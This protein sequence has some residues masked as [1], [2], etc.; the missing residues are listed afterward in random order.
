MESWEHAQRVRAFL[1]AMS[2]RAM[3]FEL[4]NKK[5]DVQQVVDWTQEYAES[6]DPYL[7]FPIPLTSL[8]IPSTNMPGRNGEDCE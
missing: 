8:S 2:E 5:H 3:Q 1:G 4:P 7:I 6:L